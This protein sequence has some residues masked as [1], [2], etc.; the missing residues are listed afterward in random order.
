MY[1]YMSRDATA[2]VGYDY[3]VRQ[4]HLTR[5]SVPLE[6]LKQATT[7]KNVLI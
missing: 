5:S 2:S 3:I 1:N 6:V 4:V 7:T